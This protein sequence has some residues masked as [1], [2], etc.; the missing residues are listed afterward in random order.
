VAF[1][2]A[3]AGDTNLEWQVDIIDA[4]NFLAGGKCY[5]GRPATWNQGDFTY[6]GVVDILDAASFLS[7]G[8]F[9]AGLYNTAAAPSGVAAVPEPALGWAAC[10]VGASLLV[11]SRRWRH[12]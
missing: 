7:T 5:S 11:R 2:F 10:G 4:G 12:G 1:A 8:L 9:D 6:D 3:A